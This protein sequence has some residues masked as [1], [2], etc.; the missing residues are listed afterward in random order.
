MF[1]GS[2]AI[3]LILA[4]LLITTLWLLPRLQEMTQLH[5]IRRPIGFY[6]PVKYQVWVNRN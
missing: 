2:E 5:D 4:G 6:H 3:I 1:I